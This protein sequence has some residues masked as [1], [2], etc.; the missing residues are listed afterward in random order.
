MNIRLFL[1]TSTIILHGTLSAQ[2]THTIQGLVTNSEG[3]ALPGAMVM[4]RNIKDSSAVST[5]YTDDDGHYKLT[6]SGFLNTVLKARS[7]GFADQTKEVPN[8][9]NPVVNFVMVADKT[10]TGVTISGKKQIIEEKADRTIFNVENSIT[11]IGGD[12]LDA[13]KKTPGVMVMNNEI[14]LAGKN[15]VS[16]MINGR[17]QQLS[18]QD[19]IQLLHSI[20]SDNLSKIEVI[21]APPAKYDAEGNSGMINLVTKKNLKSGLKGSAAAGYQ[22]NVVGS[23]DA[24]IMLN[25]RKEKLNLFCNANAGDFAWKYTSRTTTYY[26]AQR[27][28]QGVNQYSYNKNGTLQLGADYNINKV[29][30]IGFQF[31][32][33]ISHM[34]N[35]DVTIS[36]SFNTAT[37]KID[38]FLYTRGNT[39]E[40]YDGKHT[41]NLNYEWKIDT[42]GRKLNIDADY[43]TQVA[44]KNRDFN[45]QDYIQDK[46]TGADVESKLIA[47]P[48]ITIKS[49]KADVEWPLKFM[50]LSFGG[51]A[52]FVDNSADNI[53][54]ILNGTEYII[55][56]TRTNLFSYAEQTQALYVSGHK[57]VGKY[58]M[59]IGLRGEHTLTQTNSPTTGLNSKNE[60]TQLFPT[61]Y[62]QYKLNDN[63]I[64]TF[65]FSRRINRPGY[66]MLNPFR[67]Y[68]STNSYVV[69]NPDLKPSYNNGIELGYRWKS[70]YSFKFFA[71]Q[72]DNYW[73]RLIQTDTVLG[74]TILTRANIGIAR[75]CGLLINGQF[76]VT[77]WWESRNSINAV[78][79]YF[80]LHYYYNSTVVLDGFN[81]W[82]ETDNSFFLNK[83]KT[84]SAELGAYYYTPRQKDYKRW[85]AMTNITLGIK[86]LFLDK[87]LIVA[88]EMED[89]LAKAYWQQTNVINGTTEFSYDNSRGGRL[90]VT[91]KFGNKNVKG[92]RDRNVNEEIQRIN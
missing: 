73:D 54:T 40:Y 82:F 60:Y 67:F 27:W 78:Y 8:E 45:T 1:L 47:N 32:E 83:S 81:E 41:L 2:T 49:I 33:G 14:S 92:R 13:L 31:T 76:Q 39:H 65:N 75:G 58:D 10:L 3:K 43:Y 50:A 53:Y 15:S 79:N 71:R 86:A 21:T 9:K 18:G 55:D 4:L 38:S 80:K 69:G 30:V 88:L 34:D 26:P 84:L 36:N 42:T 74:T 5:E 25:Y 91:Y 66:G 20:P 24:S 51:K 28:E 37:N 56:T 77:K 90:S 57:S 19:L 44:K 68:Y 7:P 62:V 59:Q 22:Q 89:L 52:A 61:G 64:F 46:P 48:A 29:S 23:P 87:N 17:I 35:T 85:G 70:R 11:A 72:T 63:N 6:T 12:A 16:V